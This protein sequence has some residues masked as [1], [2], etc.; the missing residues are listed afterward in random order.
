MFT[1]RI[2]LLAKTAAISLVAFGISVLSL[3]LYF[4][5][6]NRFHILKSIYQVPLVFFAYLL[7]LL[8]GLVVPL[9]AI[10]LLAN[11][12]QYS[13]SDLFYPGFIWALASFAYAAA[14]VYSK[15]KV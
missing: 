14:K 12:L 5:F 10:E 3:N 11:K 8:L 6:L 1:E 7:C 9:A 4:R 15:R 2:V 13:R